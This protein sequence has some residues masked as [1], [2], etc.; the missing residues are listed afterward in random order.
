MKCVGAL[1]K[2]LN[3]YDKFIDESDIPEIELILDP[4]LAR[5]WKS[6]IKS[7]TRIIYPSRTKQSPAA[8]MTE[9]K[10]RKKRV[11]MMNQVKKDNLCLRLLTGVFPA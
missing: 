8:I 1:G 11:K 7:A 6:P 4:S 9:K 5:S 3:N 10:T 2:L